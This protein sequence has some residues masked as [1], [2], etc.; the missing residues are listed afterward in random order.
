MAVRR[1][2]FV[3]LMLLGLYGVGF[4]SARP[5]LAQTTPALILDPIVFDVDEG[6]SSVVTVRLSTQPTGDVV[7]I[8]SSNFSYCEGI[9]EA[10]LNASNWQEGQYITVS[11]PEDAYA[12]SDGQCELSA[13]V[14]RSSAVEYPGGMTSTPQMMNFINND[15]PRLTLTNNRFT[16]RPGDFRNYRVQL[17]VPPL[18][19]VTVQV[20]ITP[21]SHC[22]ANKT[23]L[24]F[25]STNYATAQ[26]VRVRALN[27]PG[28]RCV[29]RHTVVA[30]SGPY[31]DIRAPQVI[32]Q[33][34]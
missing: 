1:L 10:T 29:I 22:R 20:F 6:F 27:H 2:L 16:F 13:Y 26:T 9:S 15:T 4:E 12:T 28:T 34:R 14:T 19:G 21:N 8:L 11:Y 30:T 17:A 24:V 5:T 23:E 33:I 3:T 18:P 7:V 32:G 31:D 25:N